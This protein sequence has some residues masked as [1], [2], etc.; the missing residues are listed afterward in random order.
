M[1]RR[2]WPWKKKSSDKSATEK[3]IATLESAGA[4]SSLSGIHDNNKNPKY[5]QISV[6]SY[7]HLTG[8]EDQLKTYVD[9]VKKYEDRMT[10]YEDRVKEYD[11]QMASYDDKVK[12]LEDVV[13][14]LNEKLSTANLEMVT[15]ESLVKKHAKVA[16][17]AV[18]GWEKAEAEALTLKSNLES[19]ALLKLTAED[20]ASHLDCALKDCMR[21]IRNVKEEHEET[22]HE[23]AMKTKQFDMIRLELET[24]LG[25]LEQELLRSASDNAV[26]SRSLQERSN[27]LIK[28]TEDKSQADA[29]IELLKNNV[30]SCSRE[31]SSLKY[32]LHVVAKELEIRN[33]EKNMS[34]R[35]AEV[36]NKQYL[37][38]LKKIAKL[39]ADCQRL[40]GLVQ[41][42]LPG[43][44]AL[45]QMKLE[46]ERMDSEYG[47]SRLRKSPAKPSTSPRMTPFTEF[48][49]DNVQNYRKEIELLTERLLAMEEE[50][51]MLKEALAKRNSELQA[52]RS[53]CAKTVTKLRSLEEQLQENNTSKLNGQILAEGSFT[54][55]ASNPPSLTSLSEDG[56]DDQ[57]FC[58]G[59]CAI[60]KACNFNKGKNT[61][62]P[63]KGENS[64][65]LE[66]MD[67]FLEM[68]K[69]AYSSKRSDGTMASFDSD[70]R[71][72]EIVNRDLSEAT[73]TK[74]LQLKDQKGSE[75]LVIERSNVGDLS[76]LQS[77]I[78]MIFE[79]ASKETD[80]DQLLEDIRN[81]VQD[82]HASLQ[83][84]SKSSCIEE[85]YH[86]NPVVDNQAFPENSN[87]IAGKES[88]SSRGN[89]VSHTISEELAAAL[90]QIYEF[91]QLLGKEG[92]AVQ[93]ESLEGDELTK[94]LEEFS[95]AFN[96]VINSR[97]SMN[98][99]ILCLSQVFSKA[100]YSHFDT[101]G[102]K[103]T[104]TELSISDCID[105]V[106]L[107]ENKVVTNSTQ[108]YTDGCAHFSDSTSDPD[109]PHDVPFVPTS[110]LKAAS[111][112][113]SL[114]DFRLLKSEKDNLVI[115][116]A[117]S[118]EN[119]KIT[120]SQL[121]ENEELLA[122]AKS[123]LTSAQKMNSLAETQLKCMAESYRSLEKHADELQIKVDCLQAKVESLENELR[124]ERRDL[125]DSL[126]R[127][128]VLQEDLIR[129]K[130]FP[131]VQVDVRSSQEKELAAAAEKLAECQET[132]SL[133]GKHL[134]LMRPQ[135]EFVG[136]PTLERT[137][138]K[139]G[140]FTEDELTSSSML[141]QNVDTSEIGGANFAAIRR[142]GSDS[143]IFSKPNYPSDSE[144][145]NLS[146]SPIRTKHQPKH[147]STKSGS[148]SFTSTPEKHRGVSRFF[149]TKAKN[150]H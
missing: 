36:A 146:R 35:S 58:P 82:M 77:R 131:V 91:V 86:T 17:E 120:M 147:R 69:L 20:R 90:S 121:Q 132:I 102:Y 76:K 88:C 144:A 52:S 27:M 4:P 81:E 54:Q 28:I 139:D 23:V 96:Q 16:E 99:F 126:A 31:I 1:D 133:L 148:S 115:D 112:N 14:E 18:S 137:P 61:D 67:D 55:N 66:L 6:E 122:E 84:N 130:S 44:A 12:E 107:P 19:V 129:V 3:V 29:A 85:P 25:N 42:K 41:K 97:A 21:Q 15:K 143:D 51:K 34:V 71:K 9:K 114:E 32:E 141:L 110:E 119:L 33:E 145:S 109:I 39:E 111:W 127:C 37:E 94:I 135:M 74:C 140:I 50:T 64:D 92:K 5:V 150:E 117:R 134:D 106:A 138:K 79:C 38:G 101:L 89:Q 75:S 142:V 118:T 7:S 80:L 49:H 53:V 56:N 63:R 98:N 103:C 60:S 68:E 43:P 73:A 113:Y 124:V 116:L 70:A 10:I 93:A 128:N 72:F 87:D 45:A 136:S 83:Q 22:L 30:D 95:S 24:Q 2:S 62:N 40:R 26:I 108:V 105:K 57:A 100:N 46:V 125:A 104:E 8:L 48:S 11:E 78:S 149:S 123:Q 65:Q 13:E 47:E 59:F